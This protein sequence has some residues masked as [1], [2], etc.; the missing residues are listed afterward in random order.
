MSKYHA[1]RNPYTLFPTFSAMVM[2]DWRVETEV[3]PSFMKRKK[4]MNVAT[5]KKWNTLFKAAI[6]EDTE[7]MNRSIAPKDD[8]FFQW[9]LPYLYTTVADTAQAESVRKEIRR[10]MERLALLTLQKKQR[11]TN[12]RLPTEIRAH[13]L[14]FL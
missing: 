6:K 3:V 8:T 13:I 7:S 9:Y 12:V 5:L 2:N 1:S 4:K 11:N 10:R 14:S